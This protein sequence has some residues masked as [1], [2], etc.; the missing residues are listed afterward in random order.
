MTTAAKKQVQE[1]EVESELEDEFDEDE[2]ITGD[3]YVFILRS[4]GSIKGI[5]TPD[6]DP[7][8]APKSVKKICKILGLENPNMIGMDVG[9]LH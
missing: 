8:D 4:D 5:I 1:Q 2:S 3:D 6:D 7:F 9:M